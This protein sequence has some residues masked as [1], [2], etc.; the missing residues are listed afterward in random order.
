MTKE[1]MADLVKCYGQFSVDCALAK[2]DSGEFDSVAA[3]CRD[4][5]VDMRA[6]REQ[7]SW[8]D[9]LMEK[10]FESYNEDADEAAWERHYEAKCEYRFGE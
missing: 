6:T 9:W 7:I 3:I 1:E 4:M 2:S 10:E 8:E 5:K